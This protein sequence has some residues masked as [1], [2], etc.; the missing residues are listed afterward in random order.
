MGG[1]VSDFAR[2]TAHGDVVDLLDLVD[3]SGIVVASYAYDIWGALISVSES[4][5][6]GWSNLSRYD[7]RDGV[8][9]GAADGLSWMS[10]RAYDPTLGRFI[11]SDPLGRAPL[12]FADQPYA[13]AGN[14]LVSNIDPSGQM[15]TQSAG[16]GDE[17]Q[18][19]QAST[20]VKTK[21][22][23]PKKSSDWFVP[24]LIN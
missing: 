16:H 4:F 3:A 10:V 20:R 17:P 24:L 19:K 11:S 12:F 18:Q 5:A 15:F 14:N 23:A 1:P 6:N 21:K 22:G 2:D 13:Y 7:G 8:R 9:Y